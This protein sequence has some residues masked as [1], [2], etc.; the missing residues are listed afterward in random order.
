MRGVCVVR[1]IL[2]GLPLLSPPRRAQDVHESVQFLLCQHPERPKFG[3]SMHRPPKP[4]PSRRPARRQFSG[5]SG[6][7]RSPTTP[8]SLRNLHLD[9]VLSPNSASFN[10]NGGGASTTPAGSR[11][12]GVEQVNP[13]VATGERADFDDC[14][15]SSDN[16]VAGQAAP[17]QQRVPEPVGAPVKQ[18]AAAEPSPAAL[19]SPQPTAAAGEVV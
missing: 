6:L 15:S 16:S 10:R 17:E 13:A 2:T 1:S 11:A 19:D 5:L 9:G 3:L 8:G 14:G 12:S 18:V 7:G 4:G